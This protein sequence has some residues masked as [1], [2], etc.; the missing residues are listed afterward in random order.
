MAISPS[1]KERRLTHGFLQLQGHYLFED[2][3]C[4]VR[5][6][7]EK[8]TVE[9]MVRYTRSNFIVPVPVVRDME[10]LNTILLERCREDMQRRL[11]GKGVSKKILLGEDQAAFLSL[12]AT[13]FDACR[14]ISTR[15]SYLS[16]VRFD[17]NDYSVP[18]R[19]AHHPVVVKGYIDR[20]DICHKDESIATHRRI[21]CKEGVSFEPLHYLALLE[22]KTGALDHARPLEGWQLPGCFAILRRRLED[23]RAGEGTREYIR[24]LRLMERHSITTLSREV[25]KGL[26]INALTE[27]I[28]GEILI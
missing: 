5:R 22:R 20:V 4:R 23:E 15:T 21:W 27:E 12:P 25:E 7:N 17:C 10:E 3:F 28:M 14:K 11:R 1:R 13:E 9:S 16:L 6:P 19:Y 2:H 18:V 24:V 8:D 26:R